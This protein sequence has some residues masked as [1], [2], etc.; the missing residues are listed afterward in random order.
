MEPDKV[1]Q[2]LKGTNVAVQGNLDPC[3]LYAP[4]EEL[5]SMIKDM[6]KSWGPQR[7]IVNLGHGIYPDVDPE[8]MK[9]FVDTVHNIQI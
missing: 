1:R 7:Y 2:E 4:K 9:I 3:A 5:E 6:V 8:A